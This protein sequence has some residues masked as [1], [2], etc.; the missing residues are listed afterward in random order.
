MAVKPGVPVESK[1]NQIKRRVSFNS[2]RKIDEM[3]GEPVSINRRMD[4]SEDEDDRR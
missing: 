3:K 4:E 2:N 1:S